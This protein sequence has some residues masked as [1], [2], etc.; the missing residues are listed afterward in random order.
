MTTDHSKNIDSATMMAQARLKAFDRKQNKKEGDDA[1]EIRK[2]IVMALIKD[3]DVF[4]DVM[5][6]V[7]IQMNNLVQKYGGK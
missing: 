6:N 5:K 3:P 7:P 4:R 2:K 1:I